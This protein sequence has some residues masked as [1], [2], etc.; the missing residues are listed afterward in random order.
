MENNEMLKLLCF[1]CVSINC[2]SVFAVFGFFYSIDPEFLPWDDIELPWYYPII[3]STIC[4]IIYMGYLLFLVYNFHLY[5]V[6]GGMLAILIHFLALQTQKQRENI[7][8]WVVSTMGGWGLITA[9]LFL[10]K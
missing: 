4:K 7:L 5:G 8:N 10:V 9:V 2:S 3:W 6:I 1:I